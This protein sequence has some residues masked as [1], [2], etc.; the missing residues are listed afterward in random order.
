MSGTDGKVATTEWWNSPGA[1][2]LDTTNSA[3][4]V[5]FQSL[6][7]KLRKEIGI[8]SFKFDAGESY[9][10]PENY[11]LNASETDVP[12]EWTRNYVKMTASFGNDIEIRSGRDTMNYPVFVRILDRDS[13]WVAETGIKSLVPVVLT[14]G[15]LGY[16]FVLPDMVGGNT[17]ILL[18]NDK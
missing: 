4:V 2:I 9:Y 1:A 3:A 16:P 10:L 11:K 15:L 7:E 13:R 6:L 8:H 18:S 14:F 5:W 12:E 17:Y